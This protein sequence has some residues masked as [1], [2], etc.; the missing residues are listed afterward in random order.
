MRKTDMTP[1]EILQIDA[2]RNHPP[3]TT[4]GDLIT[5][6][7]DEIRAGGDIIQQGNTLIVYR[8]IGDGV[9][10][11]HSFNADTPQN[12]F[13]ANMSLWKMLRKAGATTARTTYQNPKITQL[14]ELAKVE[15][16]ID[17]TEDAGTFT[18]E[19]RL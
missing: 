9:V 11:H 6:I 4:V 15:F 7:N 12:L 5:N 10:E 17:I 18:A 8:G 19:V 2:E 16:D 1:K 3:G 13:N 14:L